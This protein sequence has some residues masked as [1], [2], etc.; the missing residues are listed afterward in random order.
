MEW[1]QRANKPD[2][3]FTYGFV[4][5]LRQP[6]AG[7]SYV[8][9]AGAALALARAARFYGDD[10]SAAIARQAVL[11]L[12]LETNIDAKEPQVRGVP[13]HLANSVAAAGTLLAAIHE[14]PAPAADLL[15]QADQ[16]ANLLRKQLQEDGSLN[17]DQTDDGGGSLHTEAVQ[18]YSGPGLYGLVRSQLLRPAPWKLDA[19]RRARAYYYSYWQQHRNVSMLAWH[20]AAYAEAYLLTKETVF[21]DAVFDMNDWLCSLQSQQALPGR[22]AWVGG[23]QPCLEAKTVALSPDITSASA[24]ISLA[25]ACRLARVAGDVRHYQRYGQ[26]L[27]SGLQFL[28]TLQYSEANTQHYADWYRPALVG[29]FHASHQDGNVRLDYTNDALCALVQYLHHTAAAP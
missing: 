21:A 9:Q 4:P 13:L 2:G 1:L 23:F 25:E 29:A 3:R 24:L 8:R 26:A 20:T 14:L 17:V 12:L 19:L 10:R 15:E 11:T 7:D 22:A 16:L 6:L 18:H 5:A 28:T 27:E